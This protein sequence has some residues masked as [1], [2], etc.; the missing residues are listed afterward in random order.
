MGSNSHLPDPPISASQNLEVVDAAASSSSCSLNKLSSTLG[1][2]KLNNCHIVVKNYCMPCIG[3]WVSDVSEMENFNVSNLVTYLRTEFQSLHFTKTE[4]KLRVLEEEHQS[5]KHV[6]S[7]EQELRAVKDKCSELSLKLWKSESSKTDLEV[8]LA[9][10]DK[11]LAQLKITF[12]PELELEPD[13][14]LNHYL[15]QFRNA[16]KIKLEEK[17][18]SNPLV[19]I[20]SLGRRKRSKKSFGAGEIKKKNKTN[21]QGFDIK[22]MDK[23][24]EEAKLELLA[25]PCNEKSSCGILGAKID[26]GISST[27]VSSP[28]SGSCHQ[29]KRADRGKIITCT[30]C[31]RR[32]CL[33]CIQ[34]RYPHLS[35]E[36]IEKSCPAC[37]G[38]CNCSACVRKSGIGKAKLGLQQGT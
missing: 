18:K 38:I 25:T 1:C 6:E 36:E 30:N 21:D 37:Q 12:R 11:E 23:D 10:R 20:H 19:E 24:T 27:R 14:C 9:D 16:S 13:I 34:K 28:G 2:S 3:K 5:W 31:K 29:C 35:H 4:E 33:L 26:K 17:P 32:Y 8:E 22:S 7:L 15:Q